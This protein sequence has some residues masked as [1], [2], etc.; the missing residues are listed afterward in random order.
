MSEVAFSPLR[1]IKLFFPPIDSPLLTTYGK[2]V[3]GKVQPLKER[4]SAFSQ[5][6]ESRVSDE[7]ESIYMSSIDI[8]IVN[9]SYLKIKR[10]RG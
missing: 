10:T 3:M 5:R 6:K 7:V 2:S 1:K 4:F 8:D 9:S